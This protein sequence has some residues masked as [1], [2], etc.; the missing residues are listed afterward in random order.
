MELTQSSWDGE[1][2]SRP[3]PK[4][5][6]LIQ[7]NCL[8]SWDVFLLLFGSITQLAHPPSIV[9]LQDSP[10]YRGKLPSFNLFSA[11][12]PPHRRWLQAPCCFL[13]LQVVFVYWLPPAPF[14]R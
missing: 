9:A 8:G 6:T 11:F 7:H 5:F 10:V 13:R 4:P 1:Q 3:P 2:D 14:F 12:S